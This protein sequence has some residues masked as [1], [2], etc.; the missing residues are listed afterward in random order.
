[1]V[2]STVHSVNAP[3][4][5]TGFLVRRPAQVTSGAAST[6]STG[7]AA[8]AARRRLVTLAAVAPAARQR[9]GGGLLE[10]IE[11]IADRLVDPGDAG[12]GDGAGDDA[13]LVG[14]VARVVRLPQRV[15]TP[16]AAHVL[17]D[18]RHEVDR[19]ARGAA[20]RDEERHVGRVQQRGVGARDRSRRR[21]AMAAVG[22]S[23]R[24]SSANSVGTSP[25]SAGFRRAS[26]RCSMDAK[27]SRQVMSSQSDCA[28]RGRIRRRRW[29]TS[30]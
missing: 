13:D 27:R 9:V 21:V 20:Q 25:R 6:M 7:P 30:T 5:A 28:G 3:R 15:R 24:A 8:T 2:P 16:P 14:R 4:R 18:D 26:A 11:Q 17:V 23:S 12:D 19:L 1:M 29:Q 22:S 10:A